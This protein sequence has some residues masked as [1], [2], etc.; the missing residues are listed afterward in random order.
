LGSGRYSLTVSNN[1][2]PDFP[3]GIVP[4]DPGGATSDTDGF[5][6]LTSQGSVE[7]AERGITVVVA[8]STGG[9]FAAFDNVLFGKD[10]LDLGGGGTITGDIGSNANIKIKA[11]VIGNASMTGTIDQ[12]GYVSGTVTTGAPPVALPDV[13]CPTGPYGPAPTGP[14][15][16]FDPV[17]GDL[18]IGGN[19]DSSWAAGTY[20]FHDFGKCCNGFSHFPMGSEVVIYF[21]GSFNVNG[22]G[23]VNPNGAANFIQI[24]ACGNDT[25]T[26]KVNGNNNT[27]L[28]LYA[29]NHPLE[30]AENGNKNGAYVGKTI[31]K[32]GNG[33]VIYDASAT[34]VGGSPTYAVVRG[35]WT[36]VW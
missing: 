36:E 33:H 16:T 6:V 35:T 28:A 25:S 18:D 21:S 22:N 24:F 11:D 34:L 26:W 31:R 12:P 15:V 1:I 13:S 3:A 4:L 30:F 10:G 7:R 2:S 20:Y 14:G 23:F 9:G 19:D 29:P 5:L 17:T 8:S 27:W 32:S